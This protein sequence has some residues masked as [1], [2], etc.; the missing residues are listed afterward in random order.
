M[1]DHPKPSGMHD[2]LPVAGYVPQPTAKIDLVNANKV[3]EEEVLRR[4]DGLRGLGDKGIIDIDQGWLA[5]GRIGIE[6]AFMD[7][8]RAIF[9]PS[10]INLPGDQT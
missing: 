4:L 8:N 9:Q 10:R 5:R 1:T 7:I 2:G 6:R 3:L